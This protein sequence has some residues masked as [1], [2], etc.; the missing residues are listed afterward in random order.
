MARIA[1]GYMLSSESASLTSSECSV[2]QPSVHPGR[3]QRLL[4]GGMCGD[5]P[6]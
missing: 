6:G 3:G 1:V 2:V 4:G 5:D